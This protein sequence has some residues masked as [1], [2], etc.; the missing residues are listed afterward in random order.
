M[1]KASEKIIFL[2]G[3]TGFL[4]S[5][6]LKLLIE[7]GFKVFCLVRGRDD[8][9]ARKRVLDSL[10]FWSGPKQCCNLENIV[11]VR[12][13]L[14]DKDFGF[15]KEVV[16]LLKNEINYIFHCAAI[17]KLTERIDELRKVN[18][19]G[20]KRVMDFALACQ[21]NGRLKK[22]NHISTAYVCGNYKGVFKESDCDVGQGFNSN[23]ERS[24]FEAEKIIE[25]YRTKGLWID[26][27]R[28]PLVV[29][30]SSTGRV[31]V[32]QSLFQ[33]IHLLRREVFSIFPAKNFFSNI[34]TIDELINGLITLGILSE[35]KNQNYHIFSSKVISFEEIINIS[36]EY[37]GF[38]KPEIVT[39]DEFKRYRIT[40]VQGRMLEST[41]YAFNPNVEL[42][43]VMTQKA[44][45]QYNFKV[46]DFTPATMKKLLEYSK[47]VNFNLK[48][49]V[50]FPN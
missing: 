39:L 5:Y 11:T 50:L 26:I 9:S 38:K 44:L 15:Q 46:S 28:P 36:S 10:S 27:F 31:P 45:A 1:S 32:F 18:V 42:D 41:L 6:L 35:Q 16:D 2:T 14:A 7:K 12:G 37:F 43:S 3:A 24:K 29:G 30:E 22:V 23:Y 8:S 17:T 4:G 33:A 40:A 47:S 13:D 48:K 21:K 49:K 34:I 25:I 19:N 20:T